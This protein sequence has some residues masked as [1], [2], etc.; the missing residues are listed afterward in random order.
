[1]LGNSETKILLIDGEPLTS[2]DCKFLRSLY[3]SAI[4]GQKSLDFTTVKEAEIHRC[5]LILKLLDG[6]DGPVKYIV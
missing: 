2:N 3:V 5:G 1:M 6:E 4:P